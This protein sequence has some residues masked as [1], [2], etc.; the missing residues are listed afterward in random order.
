MFDP[1]DCTGRLRACPFL[2][3]WRALLCGQVFVWVPDGIQSWSFFGRQ[4]TWNIIFQER[5]K[6]FAMPYVLRLIAVSPK[7]GWFEGAAKIRQYE[8]VGAAGINAWQGAPWSEDLNGKKLY[9]A[10]W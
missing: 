1:G 2:G 5:Y 6:Q 10:V 7:S 3:R 9:V 4:R 8:A